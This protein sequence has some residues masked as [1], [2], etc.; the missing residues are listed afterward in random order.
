MKWLV[1]ASS[2]WVSPEAYKPEVR[3]QLIKFLLDNAQYMEN[4]SSNLLMDLYD[5]S[6]KLD[7]IDIDKNINSMN[8]NAIRDY[9]IC[10]NKI[11]L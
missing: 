1:Y 7:E 6:L 11:S 8:I 5:I 4:E 2:N 10:F 3:Q 9:N